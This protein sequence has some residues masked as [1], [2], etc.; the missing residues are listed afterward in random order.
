M[1]LFQRSEQKAIISPELD[2]DLVGSHSFHTV[3]EG[4]FKTCINYFKEFLKFAKS[5]ELRNLNDLN[6]VDGSANSRACRVVCVQVNHFF[7]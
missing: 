5:E 7:R 2:W 3:L 1:K 6:V 4:R